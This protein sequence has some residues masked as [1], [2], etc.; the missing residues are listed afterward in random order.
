MYDIKYGEEFT[1]NLRKLSASRRVEVLDTIVD[2]STGAGNSKQKDLK[3][4]E[5]TLGS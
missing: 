2:S 3:R 5:S 1:N 4:V